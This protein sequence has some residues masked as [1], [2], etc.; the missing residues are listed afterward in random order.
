[1]AGLLVFVKLVNGVSDYPYLFQSPLKE[2][3]K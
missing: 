2:L 1:M 3:M